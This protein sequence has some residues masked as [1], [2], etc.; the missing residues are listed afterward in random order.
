MDYFE[1]DRALSESTELGGEFNAS[2]DFPGGGT[3]VFRSKRADLPIDVRAMQGVWLLLGSLGVFFFSSIILYVVYIALR[4][5]SER[6]ITQRLVLP[7]SF[8]PSTLLLVGVSVCLELGLRA[9]RRDRHRLVKKL[10]VAACAMGIGFLFVQSDGMNRLLIGL[11]DAPTRN[12]SAYG[13]TFIL[14]FLHAAHVVGGVV[15]LWWT[16]RNALADRYDHERTVG[17]WFCTLYWHFLDIV[18]V[19][20]LVSF[21]IALVLVNGR[22]GS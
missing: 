18:W 14:A 17:L 19:L 3:P 8:I 6:A 22:I 11:A 20:L 2:G 1:G 9:A 13:Y 4:L 5:Q 7:W 15:G 16:A 10:V 21:W 12:E